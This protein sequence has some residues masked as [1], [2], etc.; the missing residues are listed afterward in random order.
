MSIEA[1]KSP[2]EDQSYGQYCQDLLSQDVAW[3]EFECR[4]GD[5][6]QWVW[7]NYEYSDY[8]HKYT[9]AEFG[10]D[11]GY[12]GNSYVVHAMYFVTSMSM[13]ADDYGLRKMN[14]WFIA[15]DS[16]SHKEEISHLTVSPGPVELD[17]ETRQ[18]EMDSIS[19]ALASGLA[20]PNQADLLELSWTL[21]I[22]KHS[23]ANPEL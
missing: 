11:L 20:V 22:L 19:F 10:V 23:Q 5:H 13:E 21:E 8:P 9:V 7:R 4:P 16:F 1:Y 6:Q 18:K 2:S 14:Q 17:D 12:G 15:Y 3:Q